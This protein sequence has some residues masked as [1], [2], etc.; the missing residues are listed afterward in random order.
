MSDDESMDEPQ[1]QV[2]SGALME[3]GLRAVLASCTN[4]NNGED[5][6][7]G[8]KELVNSLINNIAKELSMGLKDGSRI[9]D[10]LAAFQRSND[11]DVGGPDDPMRDEEEKKDHEEEKK[12][13]EEEKEEEK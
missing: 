6:E 2:L 11:V 1:S 5:S 10:L 12:D 4:L 7:E 13:Y 8:D 3:Q 9:V